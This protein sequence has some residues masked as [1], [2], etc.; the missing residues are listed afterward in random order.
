[1]ITRSEPQPARGWKSAMI[2]YS[3]FA[4]SAEASDGD[5]RPEAGAGDRGRVVTVCRASQ[6]RFT[7]GKAAPMAVTR[8]RYG[9]SPSGRANSGPIEPRWRVRRERGGLHVC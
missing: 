2:C 1:M 9:P 7:V 3:E 4:Y 6:Q 5:I 8:F